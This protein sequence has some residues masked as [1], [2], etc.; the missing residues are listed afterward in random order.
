[1]P[2]L[3]L[4]FADPVA[5]R[6]NVAALLEEL[7][8]SLLT[9]GVFEP[10]SVKSRAYP[11]HQWQVGE[12]GDAHNF[13]HLELALLSGR[14]N[15]CKRGL[16]ERLMPL[17]EQHAATIDSLTIEIRDMESDTYLKSKR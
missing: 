12:G 9:C 4:E 1:M 11:C 15:D 14:D 10:A 8:Q 7:H 6:V 3:K 13:I 17:L 5:E 16:A 2:H